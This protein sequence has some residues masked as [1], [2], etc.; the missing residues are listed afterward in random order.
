MGNKSKHALLITTVGILMG[1]VTYPAIAQDSG[2]RSLEEIVVVARKREESLN[3]VPVAISAFTSTAL[4]ARGINELGDVLD[5]TVGMVYN[6]RDGNRSQ[7]QPGV[8]GI[9][10]FIG[11][12]IPRVSTFVD[13]MPVAGQ[14]ATIQ[15]VD[16]EGV[17]IYRGPQSAVFGRSVFAGAINYSYRD[18]SLDGYE[19]NVGFQAGQDGRQAI[20]GYFSTS[21]IQDVLGVYVSAA[22]DSYDGPDSPVSTDGFELG[23]RDTDHYSIA[24]K[25]QPTD[26]LSMTLRYT[27]TTLDDGPAPDYNLTPFDPVNNPDGD[28]NYQQTPDQVANNGAPLYAGALNHLDNPVFA[29]NFCADEGLPTQNCIIDPGFELERERLL[30]DLS[31]DFDNGHSLVF[32][33]FD[34]EDFTFDIDDQDNSA[35][36]GMGVV[37]MAGEQMIEEEYYELIWTSPSENRLRYTLGY[38]SYETET[39]TRAF[40]V[41]PTASLT[42]VGIGGALGTLEVE[43][44]GIFGGIFYDVTDALTLSY[45][46]RQQSDDIEANDPDP[47]D[48]NVPE[49]NSDTFLP[50]VAAN[51]AVSDNLSIYAQYSRGAQPATINATAVSPVQR[52]IATGLGL[53]GFDDANSFLD[54]LIAVDEEILDSYEIGFKG[55]FLDGRL[56]LAGAIFMIETDGFVETQNVF[57]FPEGADPNDVLAD[58]NQL[59]V[60]TGNTNLQGLVTADVRVRGG[61]NSGNVTSDGIELE[62]TYL[63]GENWEL[64][65]QLTVLET[66]FDD[67]CT[68]SAAQ[69]GL[70]DGTLALPGG[71]ELDCGDVSGNAFPFS[72]DVQLGLSAAYASEFSNG[73]GWFTRL[74]LRY[75]DEQFMDRH[76]IGFLPSTTKLNLRAGISTDNLRVEAYIENLTDE[77][78]PLGAQYEPGR[79]E[80]TQATGLVGGSAVGLNVAAAYPREAGIKLSYS[81]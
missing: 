8:R 7:T 33:A 36:T 38:S 3:D 51:Y 68:P 60:D 52:D 56:R 29:R 75:E 50:R 47:T 53:I 72:P 71:V 24:F 26:Q 23:T 19:G 35:A 32:K 20:N 14:Q 67:T 45:E 66:E 81:F 18:P 76:E 13:G 42:G 25:Y 73:M 2:A 59:G 28:P 39:G 9:K 48:N 61:V 37:N 30:F 78:T 6:E 63:L 34:S 41:H 74:D 4:D 69:F 70:A 5:N 44:T 16:V 22:F 54:G 80:V 65:G 46:A 55:T 79:L 17:E 49:A 40:A 27:D 57:F 12:G 15:F 77:D 1:G 31:Y 58:L 11:G 21:L 10:D 43:N 64:S 62:A